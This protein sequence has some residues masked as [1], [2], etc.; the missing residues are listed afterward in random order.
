MTSTDKLS[1]KDDLY[2][3]QG[4]PLDQTVSPSNG[5]TYFIVLVVLWTRKLI[6]PQEDI[7]F[8][9][10]TLDAYYLQLTPCNQHS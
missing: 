2:N 4:Q 6:E 8:F 3:R 9:L 1:I 10:H 5:K 7:I